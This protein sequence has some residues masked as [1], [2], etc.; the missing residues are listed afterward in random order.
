MTHDISQVGGGKP[1]LKISAPLL[2]R[3]PSE[4]LLKIFSQMITLLINQLMNDEGVGRT[5]P[6]KLGLSIKYIS[7]IF[8]KTFIFISIIHLLSGLG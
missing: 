1:P 7:L 4:G 5:A 6:A 2:L 3:F 8:W